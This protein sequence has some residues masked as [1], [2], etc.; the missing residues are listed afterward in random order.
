MFPGG[1]DEF[2]QDDGD[3]TRSLSTPSARTSTQIADRKDAGRAD[4]ATESRKHG[5]GKRLG[6]KAIELRDD[7][8][9]AHRTDVPLARLRT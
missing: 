6:A 3:D 9:D 2:G 1:V 5:T 4:R 7:A 8:V